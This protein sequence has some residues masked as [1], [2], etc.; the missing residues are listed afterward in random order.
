[1]RA[2][3]LSWNKSGN[4]DTLPE[5]GEVWPGPPVDKIGPDYNYLD[6]C[7]RISGRD[8]KE[9][10][11]ILEHKCRGQEQGTLGWA[12]NTLHGQ[13]GDRLSEGPI[14]HLSGLWSADSS[15][16]HCYSPRITAPRLCGFT[17]WKCLSSLICKV[18]LITV[19]TPQENI[20]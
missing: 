19:P 9:G 7:Q 14:E 1:M 10:R 20:T 12:L 13:V 11:W 3:I 18:W 17:S 2:P 4:K 16:C 6:P 8:I 5:V 15:S